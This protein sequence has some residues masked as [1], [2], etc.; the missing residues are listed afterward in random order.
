[1]FSAPREMSRA[2]Q[3][4]A[5][6]CDLALTRIGKAV[7]GRGVTIID[8]GR[9]LTRNFKRGFDHFDKCD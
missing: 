7:P 4:I 9:S 5:T 3:N 1:L 2:I 6:Q 8:Q